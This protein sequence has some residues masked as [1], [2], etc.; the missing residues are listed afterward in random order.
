MAARKT[1]VGAVGDEAV[2]PTVSK[3]KAEEPACVFQMQ[4]KFDPEHVH[5][6]VLPVPHDMHFCMQCG[7]HWGTRPRR[8][9]E[10]EE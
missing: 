9:V 1:S 10:A 7:R 6:C 4:A 8:N 5:S 2:A 3:T